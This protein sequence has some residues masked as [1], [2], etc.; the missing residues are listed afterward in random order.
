MS[1]NNVD[2]FLFGGSKSATFPSIG[3]TITGTVSAPPELQQQRDMKDGKPKTW[4]DGNPMMQM[5]ITLD[6]D[7]REP[8]DDEDDGS[9]RL[10]VKSG[11]KSSIARAVKAAGAT[12]IEVGGKLTVKYVADGEQKQRGFSPPKIYE[13]SYVKPVDQALGVDPTPAS[14]SPA[15]QPQASQP[16]AAPDLGNLSPE[17]LAALQGL[18]GNK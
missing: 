4:D 15:A 10:F 14:E 9:R 13:A 8:G 12:R 6:T 3:T 16:A 7:L 18:L 5:V 1:D 17:A 11:M 2:G